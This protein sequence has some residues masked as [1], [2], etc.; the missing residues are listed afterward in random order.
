MLQACGKQY[1]TGQS[2]GCGAAQRSGLLVA[3]REVT[4]ANADAAAAD[5]D[6]YVERLRLA[7]WWAMI[8]I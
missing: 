4:R 5:P 8:R 2:P 6:A 1:C 3:G 7:G